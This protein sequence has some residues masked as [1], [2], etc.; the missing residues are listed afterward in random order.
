MLDGDNIEEYRLIKSGNT[1]E[2][3]RRGLIG[4]ANETVLSKKRL[5][6]PH[7]YN[8]WTLKFT[9]VKQGRLSGPVTQS[10]HVSHSQYQTQRAL[11]YTTQWIATDLV[12]N[13]GLTRHQ[14]FEKRQATAE[15]IILILSTLWK[16]AADAFHSVLILCAISG[17]RIGVVQ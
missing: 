7:N 15:D 11:A 12:D 10:T 1:V 8:K 5:E 2:K 16:R 4:Y 17:F 14:M 6:E 3:I 13:N 9:D